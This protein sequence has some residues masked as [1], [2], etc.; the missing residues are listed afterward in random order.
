MAVE[1]NLRDLREQAQQMQVYTHATAH[2]KAHTHTAASR[3]V[4][5][6]SHTF[7]HTPSYLRLARPHRHQWNPIVALNRLQC[8]RHSACVQLFTC[9]VSARSLS[10]S[11]RCVP[12]SGMVGANKRLRNGP[13]Q[14]TVSDR[15]GD[16]KECSS[17][18]LSLVHGTHLS[19]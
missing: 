11:A 5:P 9:K 13:D 15:C 18:R 16:T 10:Q 3:P 12:H 7:T 19:K 8:M 1:D 4:Q 17:W 6:H 2:A 14:I